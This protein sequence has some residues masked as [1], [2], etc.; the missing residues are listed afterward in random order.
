MNSNHPNLTGNKTFLPVIS[1]MLLLA[2][3]GCSSFESQHKFV[4]DTQKVYQVQQAARTSANHI[5]VIWVNPPLKKVEK[6][7]KK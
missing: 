6:N 5:D 7:K 3:T 2:L 1:T 4:V